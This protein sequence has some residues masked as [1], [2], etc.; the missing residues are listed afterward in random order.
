MSTSAGEKIASV[1][2]RIVENRGAQGTRMKLIPV[3]GLD[4]V[5]HYIEGRFLA[6]SCHRSFIAL[7][8]Y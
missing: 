4:G 5:G 6:N 8:E 2:L 3:F 7:D 1:L